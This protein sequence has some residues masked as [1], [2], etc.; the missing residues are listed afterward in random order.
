MAEQK[1]IRRENYFEVLAYLD[2]QYK[3]MQSNQKTIKRKWAHLLH[4]LNWAAD[5]PFSNAPKI[6]PTF[7]RFLLTARNDRSKKTLSASSMQRACGEARSFFNW[8]KLSH[9]SLYKD[10][11]PLWIM[12]LRPGRANSVQ[13]ELVER[14]YYTLKEIRQLVGIEP[15]RLIDQRDRAAVAM[16]FISGMRISAFV[17]LPISCVD[18]QN[19]SI[20]Q[21]PSEGVKTKNSK[22]ARTFLLPIDDLFQIVVEWDTLV[23]SQFNPS[24]YWYPNLTTDGIDFLS[25]QKAGTSDSRRVSFSRNLKRFCQLVNIPYRSPHKIRNGHGVYAVKKATDIEEF[26]AYSQNMM[27]ESMEITDRLY[28]RLNGDDVKAVITNKSSSSN[29]EREALFNDFLEWMESKK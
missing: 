24:A 21:F 22:A 15:E 13:T 6:E 19:Q 10:I 8:I 3:V 28:G 9:P 14:E 17:T 25:E 5:V 12:S 2:Y 4:L 29:S 16:L 23:R 26:K 1:L 11:K 18:L 27:H 7:P 20:D